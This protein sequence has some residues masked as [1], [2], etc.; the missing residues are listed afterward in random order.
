M[1]WFSIPCGISSSVIVQHPHPLITEVETE[2]NIVWSNLVTH[3][4]AQTCP[5]VICK[6]EVDVPDTLISLLTCNE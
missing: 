3:P 2:V 4:L 1:L 6:L 5:S